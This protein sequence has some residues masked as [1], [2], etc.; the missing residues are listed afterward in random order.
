MAP[1]DRVNDGENTGQKARNR[2]ILAMYWTNM[3][4]GRQNRQH[5]LLIRFEHPGE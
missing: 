2:H 5:Y 4:A 1:P 3:V